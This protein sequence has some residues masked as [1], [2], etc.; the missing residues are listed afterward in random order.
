MILTATARYTPRSSA[1]QF[2]A[3]K[4]TPAVRAAVAAAS[5][6]VV[7]EAKAICPVDTGA[8]RDS[9]DSVVEDKGKT[10]VGTIYANV[11]YAGYVEYGTGRRGAES[12]GAGPYEYSLGHPGQVAQPYL[13][14]ALD[15]TREAVKEVFASQ[16]AL[17]MNT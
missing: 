7:E 14:P 3:S 4:I 16:V 8:L 11:P 2:I 13:R 17:G 9:I 15:T 12:P 6:T 5:Q 1:G 10:V